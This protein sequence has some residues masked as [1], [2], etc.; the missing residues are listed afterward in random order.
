MILLF[1]Y[2]GIINR[3]KYMGNWKGGGCI[4]NCNGFDDLGYLVVGGRRVEEGVC[5]EERH[6]AMAVGAGT[7]GVGKPMG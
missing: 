6:A 5:I 2:D 1:V 4:F 7:V 3:L